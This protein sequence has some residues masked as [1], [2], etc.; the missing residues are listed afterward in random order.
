MVYFP[1]YLTEVYDFVSFLI[2]SVGLFRIFAHI[3]I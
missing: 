3:T 1:Q 2:R